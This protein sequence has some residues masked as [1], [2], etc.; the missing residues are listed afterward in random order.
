[1]KNFVKRILL[2]A[3]T[4]ILSL[5]CVAVAAVNLKT[6]SASAATALETEF[7]NNGQVV[8]SQYGSNTLEYVDGVAGATG[9]VL[10]ITQT[11]QTAFVMLSVP[12]VKASDL[13]SIVVRIYSPGYTESDS[14]R[15]AVDTSGNW[16]QNDAV[17]MG[18]WVDVTL[19]AKAIAMM[20]D[21]DGYLSMPIAVGAR[22]KSNAEYYYIDSITVNVKKQV[23]V[24]LTG[25]HSWWNNYSH[26]DMYC[27]ILEFSGG[28]AKG[29]LNSDY[30]DV[31]A[32][33]TLNGQPVDAENLDFVCR[34]WIDGA[35][36]SIV[37]RW[38][39][40]PA[41]G[42]IL[43]IP[44][45]ATF[46]NGGGDT[47]IYT[48]A[49][50]IYL[51]FD[52]SKWALTENPAMAEKATF[53]S[54]WGNVDTYNDS[55]SVLLIFNSTTAWNHTDKGTLAS[56]ITYRNSSTGDTYTATD[57]D[58]A[59]WDGQKWIVFSNLTG[60]DV[61]EI[62][63]GGNFGGVGIPALTIYNVNGR[64][65]TT[66]PHAATTHFAYIANGW[67]N[68]VGSGVSNNIFSFDV[69]PL[70]D[71]ADATNLAATTNRTSM[72][73]KYNGKTFRELYADTNNANAK[74]Y[75]ISYAHGNQH[76][77]FAIPEADLVDGAIFE[78]EEGTPFMNNYLGAVK[79][80]FIASKG[81]WEPYKEVNYNPDFNSIGQMNHAYNETLGAY[82]LSLRYDTSGFAADGSQVSTK[83]QSGFTLNGEN[84]GVALWGGNQLLFWLRKEKCEV[85][86]N[87]YEYATLEIAEG[88][89]IVNQ[90]GK[91]YT[92]KALTLYLVGGQWTTEKPAMAEKATFNSIWGNVDMYNASDRVLL[93]FN[94][95]TA[96]N[97]TDKGT[98]ASKVT[99]KNSETGATYS[100]T[101]NDIAGWDG[102][103][104]IIFTGTTDYDTIEIAAG[105]NFGGV[106]IPA[107]TIYNVNGR[108]VTTPAS[109]VTTNYLAIASGWNNL[110]TNGLAQTIVSFDLK[111]LAN[112]ADSTNLAASTNR[113][114]MMVKYNGKTF[115]ELY[116]DTTNANAQQYRISYAHGNNHFYFTVPE[117]DLVEDATF[118]IE[119]G[120][121]FAGQG[122]GAVTLVFK[123]GAW[124]YYEETNYN[125]D[126]ISIGGANH[127]EYGENYGLSVRYDTNGFT[128][129]GNQIVAKSYVGLTINN[130]AQTTVLWGGDQL[131]FWIPAYKLVEGYNGYSHPTFKIMEG[132]TVVNENDETFTLGAATLYFVNGKWTTE[133]PA[134]YSV[135]V[136]IPDLGEPDC[137][138][139]DFS[140]WNNENG[141]TLFE[142]IN[143]VNKPTTSSSYLATTG[144]YI[145][146]NG[147]RLTEV[148][149]ANVYTWENTNWLRIDILNPTEGSILIIEEGTPFAGNYL[150]KLIFEFTEGKWHQAFTVNMFIGEEVFTVYSQNDIPVVIDDVYFENLLAD[151]AIPGKVVS[152]STRGVTYGAGTTFKVLTDTDLTVE[153][154]GFDTTDGASVR[155]LTPTGIR[156]ETKIDKADYD[157]L[158]ATYGEANIET[159]TYI[160][161]KAM[162]GTTDFR[163]YFANSAKVDGTDYV[164]IV[165]VGWANNK[166]VDTDGYYLYY[167]SLVELQPINYGTDFFGI[168]YIK[169]TDGDREFIVFGGY[170]ADDF[171]RSIYYV[172]SHAYKD[173]ANGSPEQAV[174][175]S[176]LDSVVYIADDAVIST[177]IDIDGYTSPYSISYDAN[178][179]VYTV[180]G[181]A[182]IKSV[183]IGDEKKVDARTSALLVGGE[184]YYVTDY[185]LVASANYSTLTFKLSPVVN[186]A[187]L[188]DFTVE[189]ASNRGVNI[190]QL[191]DIE[192][193]DATQMRTASSLTEAEQTEYARKNIYANAFNYISTMVE[194]DR[195]D[196]IILTGDIVNGAFD[197]NGSM[198]L[199]VIEF[200]DS[201]NIPWAPV[202]G[203]MDNDSAMGAAW[204]IAQLS[205][206]KNCL[207]KAGTLGGNG[208]YTIG[209]T[210][211]GVMKR[212]IFM[213]DSNAG[214]GIN[215][216]QVN[217]MKSISANLENCYGDVPAF[218]FTNQ[219]PATTFT[220]NFK[221]ANVDGVFMGNTPSDNSSSLSDGIY[222]TYGTKTGVYGD[223]DASKLGGTYIEVAANGATFTITAECLDK[224]AME[225]KESIYLVETYDGSSV[226]TDAY[227]APLW[228]TDRI[229][230]ETAVFVGETGSVTLMYTPADPKEV[231]VRNITLGVT[232]TYGVDYTISGNKVTRVAGGNLPYRTYEEYYRKDPVVVNGVPQNWRVDTVEDDYRYSGTRYM[233]YA[234][235]Y[236]GASR[237]VTFTYNK[238]EAWTG[239]NFTGDEN[240]QAFINQLKTEKEGSIL[241]YGDSITVGCNASGT[242]W[243]GNRNPFLPSWDNLVTD[244]LARM[245]NANITKYNC[246]V[247][248]WTT[249]QGAE[250]F[251]SQVESVNANLADIDL[252][253]LAFGMNDPATQDTKYIADI[254]SMVNT[255]YAANP[256]GSV[257]LVSPM[258]PNT[259]SKMVYGNHYLWEN[260]LNKVKNSQEYS[261]KHIS[262]AKVF[263]AFEELLTVPG[264]LSRDYLGNN[265]NHPTDFGV[266]IYAQVIMKTLCG[267]DFS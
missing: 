185:D 105:G 255:Y 31:Y 16:Q 176:Y 108:W 84:V 167:G 136:N 169:I 186:P 147:T 88:A 242:Q 197:D 72:M 192:L 215:Q 249:A 22:A 41:S 228:E 241:F 126:F 104:W 99:Y 206:A 30:S 236:E 40:L 50:D 96:W 103:R 52:G 224:T 102:Q 200:M 166:T 33:A 6:T 212:V 51:K 231:V 250:N 124:E 46:K 168:G 252:L 162:L 267:D 159:G 101:N 153:V 237:H 143:F 45:G 217:W 117:T 37:M 205:S 113:T 262:L 119:E 21:A 141:A 190:L 123:N 12:S 127:V 219:A 210:D 244:S 34:A 80:V 9:T 216:A 198:W 111:P 110:I 61:I 165:N 14:F 27:S 66:A 47:N 78:I 248:G 261:T 35:A 7:T 68:N 222:Y 15:A 98:L 135:T 201:F 161:P 149:G 139:K 133:K 220:A 90:E 204:Q 171:T 39:T 137:V 174:L 151:N 245:Y 264:K 26:N 251:I 32:K 230:D 258:V 69:K 48:I 227:M 82:G 180:T 74:K 254:K 148:P 221:A 156:Y 158:V 260:A 134:N 239:T 109:E 183:I 70:G 1:M 195:P 238:T 29:D 187:T 11:T 20:T 164:K 65:V 132:A 76:F 266:R 115:R 112:A 157:A 246:A 56:K 191:T 232:Y 247:G 17:N 8:L 138:F 234:E 71:A 184:K 189:V 263:T 81:A 120:T 173:Y 18:S 95:T 85:G 60:Y 193:T 208:D 10:K 62:A 144:Y 53:N 118:E 19:N 107:L 57:A 129:A 240:A 188:V 163:A 170:N 55:D 91:E 233:Y 140:F 181:N 213:L 207:F 94:S 122:L 100:P 199:R 150:P 177:L 75:N 146:L 235:A 214:A 202:F 86:Y 125:P 243:G 63:E 2:S 49:K 67:N 257:V 4:A 152:F 223:Y 24:E 42:A 196:L 178:T 253:V 97:H 203:G 38:K 209:I 28:I 89:K 73:V 3:C 175:K 218:V 154:I 106:G 83:Q 23:S 172:S 131:L 265:I 128:S 145:T 54:I 44:A 79:Y 64:W 58:I 77:Y 142:F 225:N 93:I 36:D 92:F 194:Q 114:S 116:A 226:V 13:G 259:Q 182:E 179:G 229:Y 59:G 256:N 121:P 211:K 130:D 87:G 25:V 43:H 5:C 155:L 160:V